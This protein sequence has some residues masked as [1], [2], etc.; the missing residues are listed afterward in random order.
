M[1]SKCSE[2]RKLL[3]ALHLECKGLFLSLGMKS[4]CP[5]PVPPPR[6]QVLTGRTAH[7]SVGH[8][9]RPG[10]PSFPEGREAY[11]VYG[12]GQAFR[13]PHSLLPSVTS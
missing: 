7:P 12:K 13:S 6:A 9:Q 8:E 11:P 3:S 1:Q 4:F 5:L 10:L 2:G